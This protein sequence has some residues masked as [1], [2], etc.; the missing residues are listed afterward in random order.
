MSA[1][2]TPPLSHKSIDSHSSVTSLHR[3]PSLCAPVFDLVDSGCAFMG[4]VGIE[5]FLAGPLQAQS[6]VFHYTP[7]YRRIHFGFMASEQGAV[8]DTDAVGK[9]KVNI[10]IKTC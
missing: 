10:K 9:S 2:V 5:K 1:L 6:S 3:N 4:G 7:I 8:V